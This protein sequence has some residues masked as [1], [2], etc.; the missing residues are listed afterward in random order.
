M[1]VQVIPS[2]PSSDGAGVKIQ[3]IHG[4]QNNSLDP[5]L[6]LDE[7]R[8][9][10]PDDYGAGFPAHPHRGIET[11]TY[12]RNGGFVHEDHMGN[13]GEI[14]AGESQWMSAGRGVIHSEMPLQT[15]GLMHGFQLWINLPARHKMKAPQWQDI[16]QNELPWHQLQNAQ[17]KVIAGNYHIAGKRFSGPLQQLPGKAAVADLNLHQNSKLT[18]QSDP[19]TSLLIYVYE[20]QLSIGDKNITTRQ[21]AKITDSSELMLASDQ[22]AGALLLNGTPLTEPV[23]HYGPFVMNTQAEIDQAIRDYQQ[24]RLTDQSF[25]DAQSLFVKH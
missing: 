17:L 10:K 18:L 14:A 4:F 16:K 21:M 1:N 2:H 13:R 25:F 7:I 24:G 23:A 22:G 20:G 12:M 9:D 3:R 11:L 5:F 6:M 15:E 8:S 19:T